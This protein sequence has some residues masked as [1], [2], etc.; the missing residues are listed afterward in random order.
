MDAR[1]VEI[2]DT[3]LLIPLLPITAFLGSGTLCPVI[4][5]EAKNLS[6]FETLRFAQGNRVYHDPFSDLF[7]VSYKVLE[8]VPSR[9]R[10]VS[11]YG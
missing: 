8:S 4:L 11:K 5:S 9:G 1:R 2:G 7:L 3:L 6:A 10:L